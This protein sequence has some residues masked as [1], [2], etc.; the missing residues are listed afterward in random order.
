MA[1]TSNAYIATDGE[2]VMK[3]GKSNDVK[4]RERQIAIP[5][6]L[7]L[8]CVD[9]AAA[10]RVESNLRD[11]VIEQGGIRHFG[12]IDYFRY[13]PQIY[14][15]LC[16]FAKSADASSVHQHEISL[17]DE[18]ERLVLRYYQLL[19]SDRDAKIEWLRVEGKEKDERMAQL[20]EEMAVI[21]YRLKQLGSVDD[22]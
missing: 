12:T 16:E 2:T 9:E 18:I 3:V 5:M 17:D 21:R 14:V 22:K 4:R 20:R 11:F 7:T 19:L 13:D 15:M 8:A 6:T 1:V 10:L